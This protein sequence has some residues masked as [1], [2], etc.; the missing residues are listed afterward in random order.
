MNTTLFY[1]LYLYRQGFESL[2]MGYASAMAW[3]LF[4]IVLVAMGIQFLL[5]RR[6]MYLRSGAV[7]LFRKQWLVSL[8]VGS[9]KVDEQANKPTNQP[10]NIIAMTYK[11]NT[12]MLLAYTALTLGAIIGLFPL[13][14][15]WLVSLRP[16]GWEFTFPPIWYPNSWL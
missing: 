3:I 6:W 13:Y 8:M 16:D 5:S 1:V 12:P 14:W 10:R 11:K 4:L 2:R 7:K 9:V 15:T